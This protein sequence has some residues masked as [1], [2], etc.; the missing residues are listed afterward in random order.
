[1]QLRNETL[2]LGD[3]TM[4]TTIGNLM[5]TVIGR[6]GFAYDAYH[7]HGDMYIVG[8]YVVKVDHG[9]LDLRVVGTVCKA[10]RSNVSRIGGAK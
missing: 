4:K 3:E 5:T 10:T 2:L 1:M 9:E 8:K 7:L 6:N